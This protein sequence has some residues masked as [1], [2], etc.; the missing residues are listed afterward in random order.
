M[1]LS[2]NEIKS[3]ASSFSN[4]W[5]DTKREEADAKPFLIDF[6]NIFGISQK[7]VATFEHR[8]KKIDEASGYIDLLWPGTLLVEMKSR[9]QDLEKA[10]TQAKNYCHGLKDHELPKLI[11]ICDFHHFQ[12]YREDGLTVKFEL[13]QLLDNLQIFEELAGYQKRTYHEED[14]VNIAA[15]ELMGKLHDQ[16]K[17]VGYTGAPLE[18]Y[19]V[20]LLFILFAD[21]TTI[22]QK[23]I[24]F[25]YLEQ[26]T[27]ED[28]SDLAMHLDQLFQVLDIPEDKRLK[29]LDEQLNI[30]PYVNGSLFSERLPTAAFNSKMR[31]ILLDCCKLDWGKISPAIFGSLFQSVMDAGD[32]RNLG[33]HYTSEKN[34]MKLIKPLFLDE[35]WDEFHVAGENQNKL[36]ELHKKISKLRFL[37]PA[38]G[39]G[40]FLITAYRELRHL[41]LAIVEKL[42]KGQL[43]TNINQYFLVDLDQFYGIELGEF[44]S[45]IAQVAM[46][47]IDHQC[48]MMVSDRFGEYIPLIPLQKSAVIVND[49]A[50]RVDWQS[51]IKIFE[52]EIGVPRFHYIL[53]NPPFVGK[54]LQDLSQKADIEIIFKGQKGSG[55]LDYVSCWYMKA[56]EYID[57]FNKLGEDLKSQA[58]FVSTNS[59]VQGEQ[60]GILWS[61]LFLRY[62]TKILFAHQTFKWGNEAKN[63]AAVHV[64]I[65]GFSNIDISKKRIFEYSDIASEPKERVVTNISP[66]LVEGAD[67]VVVKR[68]NPICNVPRISFGS[69]PNDGGWLLLDDIQRANILKEDPSANYLI[70]PLLSAHEFLNGHTRWCLWLHNISPN[71]LKKHPLILERINKVREHRNNSTREATK[72]L[73][74][75]P[76]LFGEVRQPDSSYILIPR[77]SSE[78]RFIIPFGFFNSN[79]IVSDSCLFV[80]EANHFHFGVLQSTIH[81]VWVKYTCGRIKSDYRY[82]NETVYNNFPWPENPTDKQKQAVEEAA[83]VVLDARTQF[84]DS[85]LADLYD[86]NTMPPVLVKAHQQL[87]KAVDQCYRSQPFTT[88]AKRIEYLFELYE[89]YTAGMFVEVQVKQRKKK[90]INV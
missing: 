16:L 83:Q 71:E 14:P 66:Y 20:R 35:L 84:P 13:T 79:Y 57:V 28:G 46:F 53:G 15:A 69:M 74:S 31:Q 48:N 50:L 41:E 70:R 45:Q 61:Q 1:P 30:F 64:V 82:S 85:S 60:V 37:D 68:Q 90:E 56:A 2:W 12:L 26:R 38:C 51:I 24:F 23:G 89:R 18:A 8:V 43:V 49:N 11:M 19:L 63:N 33:A 34:I 5:K 75:I 81:I 52:G 87:D 40:N 58:A 3:R 86:P 32:R 80:P 17:D 29:T 10:Y 27:K 62:K 55:V 65:I 6:L 7:R 42:L 44:P 78:N 36:R 4:E 54:Q 77:H 59:I 88:E 39:C 67:V 76:T 25:D 47:L 72:K 9:G 22:F 21:D 73:S